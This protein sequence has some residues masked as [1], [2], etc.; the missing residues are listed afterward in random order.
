ARGSRGGIQRRPQGPSLRAP[1]RR[2][3][4][5]RRRG[6]QALDG[7][8]ADLRLRFPER[9]RTGLSAVVRPRPGRVPRP[10]RRRRAVRLSLRRAL[11]LRGPLGP[12]LSERPRLRGPLP[13]LSHPPLLRSGREREIQAL[14]EG[15]RGLQERA[16]PG[17]PPRRAPPAARAQGLHPPPLRRP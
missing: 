17:G 12:P 14:L 11:S 2:R 7:T 6:I 3:L 16:P 1:E 13:A 15:G 4:P 10:A 8:E 9:L 5:P